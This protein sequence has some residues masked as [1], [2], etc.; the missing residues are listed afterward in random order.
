MKVK[1]YDDVKHVAKRMLDFASEI[2]LNT[3]TSGRLNNIVNNPKGDEDSRKKDYEY[4][5]KIFKKYIADIKDNEPYKKI[6]IKIGNSLRK[7]RKRRKDS[8]GLD[9]KM[10]EI[11]ITKKR[12]D[13]LDKIRGKRSVDMVVE[14]RLDKYRD[15]LKENKKLRKSEKT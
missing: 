15:L 11:V 7:A 10:V 6:Y 1:N 4:C 13:S 2:G 9:G 14:N 8:S 12:Y 3:K 5:A